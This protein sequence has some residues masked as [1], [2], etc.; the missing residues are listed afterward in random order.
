MLLTPFLEVHRGKVNILA[1]CDLPVKAQMT[2]VMF[3]S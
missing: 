2:F 1:E 3:L